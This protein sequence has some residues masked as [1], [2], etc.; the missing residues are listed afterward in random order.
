MAGKQVQRRRGTTAQHTPFV[1]AMGEVTVDTVKFVEVVHD[2]V[3]PGGFPQA[4]ARDIVQSTAD[5][6]AKLALKVSQDSTTG[7]AKIP[8]GT[9]GQRPVTPQ[10]GDFRFNTTSRKFEGFTSDLGWTNIGSDSIPLFT[11]FWVPLRTA[12]PAGFVAADGQVLARATYPDAAAGVLAATVPIATEASWGADPA[13]RGAYTTGDGVNNFR[14]PD[15]N[16][17]TSGNHGAVFLRGDGTN[18]SGTAGIIQRDAIQDHGHP[19]FIM[20]TG[21]GGGAYNFGGSVVN[22]SQTI[23]GNTTFKADAPA[24]RPGQSN[25]IKTNLAETRPVNVTG[26]WAIKLFGA[27][28]NPGAADAAQ[29]ATEV[30]NIKA[31]MQ[32]EMWSRSNALNAVAALVGG[33]PQGGIMQWGQNAGGTWIRFMDGTQIAWNAVNIGNTAV[34][35]PMGN[36]FYTSFGPQAF[37]ISFGGASTIHCLTDF[38]TGGG[39]GFSSQGSNFCSVNATAGTIMLNPISTTT[40]ITLVWY[41]IG[42]W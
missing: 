23:Q 14:I 32:N 40:T 13:Y 42:R 27:V 9:T 2:G 28:I 38:L 3:T 5:T 33:K 37:P 11:V 30:A 29:L 22:D 1:G 26:C 17:K 16:G 35:T 4:S 25:V 18:S 24:T 6:D 19:V 36:M 41:A 20:A 39:V 15:Y 21:S 7:V 10:E 12:M 31:T 8:K 34:T